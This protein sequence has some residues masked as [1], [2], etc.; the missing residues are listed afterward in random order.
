ML[1]FPFFHRTHAE[2]EWIA[3]QLRTSRY[4]RALW[5]AASSAQRRDPEFLILLAQCAWVNNPDASDESRIRWRNARLAHWAELEDPATDD[6][7]VAALVKRL[8]LTPTRA[9]WLV[10]S[11]SG[12]TRYYPP[13]RPAFEK[14]IR[15]HAKD[16]AAI[17]RAAARPEPDTGAK[18]AVITR[19][20]LALPEIE[21]PAGGHSS[22]LNGLSPAL[23]CL[24]PQLWLATR[25]LPAEAWQADDDLDSDRR[26]SR[27]L[28]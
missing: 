27:V 28:R 13:L 15:T 7:L 1:K 22:I 8:T 4:I 10:A 18:A 23:A 17:F 25:E 21:A 5:A 14:R 20:L 2:S 26:T 6:E 11:D 12:I 9:K 24:D 16:V 19:R 3:A